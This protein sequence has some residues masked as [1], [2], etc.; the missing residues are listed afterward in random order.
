MAY[1]V[2]TSG[3]AAAGAETPA[4]IAGIAVTA[5]V[6][7]STS[8]NCTPHSAASRRPAP[9]LAATALRGCAPRQPVH[10]REQSRDLAH[11]AEVLRGVG[12]GGRPQRLL[13]VLGDRPADG[14]GQRLRERLPVVG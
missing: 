4:S 12:L 6:T 13:P 2:A 11:D 3:V 9:A 7:P 10:G 8:T 14:G 1:T 5:P